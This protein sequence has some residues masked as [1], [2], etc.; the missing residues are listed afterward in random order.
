MDVVFADEMAVREISDIIKEATAIDALGT[1]IT[2]GEPLIKLDYVIECIR[3][4]KAALGVD[5][6]IH[7]YT[8]ITPG[9]ETLEKLVQA[10][11]DEI[12]FH[13]PL[14]TWSN[15]LGLAEALRTAKSLGLIAG[16]EIPAI[17]EAP[18]IVEAVKDA[19]AFIN[20]NELEFSETNYA[21]LAAQGFM[22]EELGCG[23]V[24]SE[25]VAKKH[26]LRDDIK[27]HYCPSRFKDAVQLR[28]RLLRR[29]KRTAR[30]FDYLSDE[31]TIIHG[32]IDGDFVRA[33]QILRDL[34]VP[35]DM[36][37]I[38]QDGIDIAAPILED[39][40]DELKG[41]GCN[42]YIVERYPIESGPVVE[43]IHL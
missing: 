16:V 40:V 24:G 39:L 25:E 2:G 43:R 34:A 36:Y 19:D 33:L 6:H 4:L 37:C 11:L 30:P 28:E 9:R 10:G 3:A 38:R 21:G 23:A 27:V 20:L 26:F 22:P 15:P 5:H 18:A 1:G 14:E 32:T 42:L 17:K 8:G 35:E 31:G 13:P 41:T 12:R 7:L 29:A